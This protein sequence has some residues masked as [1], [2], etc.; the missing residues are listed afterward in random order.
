[1]KTLLTGIFSRGSFRQLNLGND[2]GNPGLNRVDY[3]AVIKI[4]KKGGGAGGLSQV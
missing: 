1:M 4:A 3:R 2:L